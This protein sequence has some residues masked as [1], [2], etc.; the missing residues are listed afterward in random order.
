MKLMK[1]HG[2]PLTD[3]AVIDYMDLY[4][5]SLETFYNDVGRP[6]KYFPE[7]DE[8]VIWLGNRG[9]SLKQI[10]AIFG[11][12]N[13][14]LYRWAEENPS[15]GEALARAR[16]GAQAWWETVGQ[17]A[18]F[19]ER[20]NTFV[21]NKIIS[22]RFRKDYTDRKGV[23]YDPNEPETITGPGEMLELDPR[24]LTDEQ[25]KVLRIAIAKATKQES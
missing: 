16:E 1:E 24:D 18:L 17:A 11:V 23:P 20:F 19:A 2:F 7:L 12:S 21:W 10:S 5:A 22:A 13:T 14:K 15:F 3:E 9:Y 4:Y 6:T 25:K 8:W